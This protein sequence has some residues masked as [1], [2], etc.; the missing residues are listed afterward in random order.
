MTAA[1]PL[2]FAALAASVFAA[3]DSSRPIDLTI[4]EGTAMAAAMSPDGTIAIDL[5]GRLWLLPISGGVA[6]RITPDL[7]EARLPSWSPDGESIAFQGYGDDGAWHIYTIRWEG[8]N[9]R[10]LTSGEFDDREPA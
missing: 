6:K 7:L 1:R 2:L 3:Q 5:L 9:L 4:T 8:T 10:A